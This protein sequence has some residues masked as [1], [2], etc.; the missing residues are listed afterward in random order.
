SAPATRG[1]D[2]SPTTPVSTASYIPAQL[3]N[4]RIHTIFEGSP[5]TE[6]ALGNSNSQAVA[7]HFNFADQARSSQIYVGEVLLAPGATVTTYQ[8]DSPLRPKSI[9]LSKAGTFTFS[10]SAP[11]D[12]VAF[13]IVASGRGEV[14]TTSVP[15]ADLDEPNP[16]VTLPF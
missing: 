8:A 3:Q 13:R 15:I 11:I 10:A 1:R 16:N 6:I 4:G 5:S 2:D 14:L 12:A 7:V 9:D